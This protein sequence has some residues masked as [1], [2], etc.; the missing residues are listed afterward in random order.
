MLKIKLR[1]LKNDKGEKLSIYLSK[2]KNGFSLSCFKVEGRFKKRIINKSKYC[3]FQ[4]I[5][6][7]IDCEYLDQFVIDTLNLLYKEEM[8]KKEKK[9]EH[10]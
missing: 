7:I 4:H 9:Y 10:C 3:S 1:D 5:K 2:Y 6:E 8:V